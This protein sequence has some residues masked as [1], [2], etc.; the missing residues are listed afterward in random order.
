MTAR[1]FDSRAAYLL[2]STATNEKPVVAD[3]GR[4]G[5]RRIAPGEKAI[6]V[7][8]AGMGD[9]TVL[10][11]L[12]R[13]LHRAF[14]HVPWL[15]VGKEISIEDVRLSLDKL[16]D[17][18]LEHPEMVFV[19]TNMSY[20]EAPYLTPLRQEDENRAE[21]DDGAARRINGL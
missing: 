20:R 18:F 11:E 19:V 9:A 4:G 8:D 10:T 7:L 16:A 3:S 21:V 1:F 17:R 5:A 14:P 12:L 2:F 6:H 15:I 13:R